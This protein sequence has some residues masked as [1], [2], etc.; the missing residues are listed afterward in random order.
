MGITPWT[1]P[2]TIKQLRKKSTCKKHPKK[3][4]K[5]NEKHFWN[6]KAFVALCDQRFSGFPVSF[7]RQKTRLAKGEPF[8][9]RGWTLRGQLK[10]IFQARKWEYHFVVMDFIHIFL[11]Y[12]RKLIFV[13]PIL[14]RQDSFVNLKVSAETGGRPGKAEDRG[15]SLGLFM[16]SPGFAFGTCWNCRSWYGFKIFC[17]I[18]ASTKKYHSPIAVGPTD[19][20]ICNQFLTPDKV[21][22]LFAYLLPSTASFPELL[23]PV[24]WPTCLSICWASKSHRAD[25]APCGPGTA[26]GPPDF[27]GGSRR[28]TAQRNTSAAM[29]RLVKWP[30]I[31]ESDF[32]WFSS[33]NYQFGITTPVWIQL[34]QLQRSTLGKWRRSW[35]LN[36]FHI[37]VESEGTPTISP[38]V[39]LCW[40]KDFKWTML[41]VFYLIVRSLHLP[42]SGIVTVGDER[43]RHQTTV[44]P[45]WIQPTAHSQPMKNGVGNRFGLWLVRG[46]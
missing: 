28:S 4:R 24:I 34:W 16:F 22:V 26:V 40:L 17:A 14:F 37:F 33:R 12:I 30:R 42:S 27:F 6:P 45:K 38:W 31:Q 2:S 39:F 21:G 29:K 10:G 41:A 3:H 5:T 13:N 44:W 23:V 36:V 25:A 8:A 9:R 15:L 11:N 7:H 35:C 1:W 43:L 46:V 32:Q 18:W 20:S 19:Q